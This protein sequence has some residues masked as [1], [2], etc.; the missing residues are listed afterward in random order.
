MNK[1]RE[2]LKFLGGGCISLLWGG[3]CGSVVAQTFGDIVWKDERDDWVSSILGG[4]AFD[5]VSILSKFNDGVYYLRAPIK[6]SSK[7]FGVSVVVPVGFVTDLASIP[8]GFWSLVPRDGPYADAAIVHDY[9]Y[10][11]QIVSKSDADRIFLRAMKDLEVS[12][13]TAQAIYAAVTSRFGELA[14]TGN[15]RLRDGG[16]KRRLSRF[17]EDPKIRWSD[18]K[19]DPDNLSD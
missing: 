15:K 3:G 18:W 10:W 12:S 8:R 1:K 4:R 7:E 2:F 14:W 9:L 17:P 13:G 19:R 16:E 5:G 6:W 11:Y